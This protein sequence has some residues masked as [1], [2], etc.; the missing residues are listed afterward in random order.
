MGN[1]RPRS[2]S[3]SNPTQPLSPSSS[4]ALAQAAEGAP[5]IGEYRYVASGSLKHKPLTPLLPITLQP[6]AQHP[7]LTQVS[8]YAKVDTG[9][10][11]TTL[12]A[13]WAPQLGISLKHD[14]TPQ[15]VGAASEQ[16]VYHHCYA[17]GLTIKVLGEDLLLPLVMF[18]KRKG[19]ALLGRYDFLQRYLVLIDEPRKRFFLERLPDP[20]DDDEDDERDLDAVVA[21]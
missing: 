15:Q 12:D 3:G 5:H 21:R 7:R 6:V 4:R 17:E 18:C 10:D 19:I 2:S 14:C 9:A 1:G 8:T 11:I 20:I 13:D 16:P